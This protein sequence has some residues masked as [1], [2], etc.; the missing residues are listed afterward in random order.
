M[1]LFDILGEIIEVP[2]KL[3]QI[4]TKVLEEVDRATLDTGVGEALDDVSDA[5]IGAAGRALGGI[6]RDLD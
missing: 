4:P 3:A 6:V 5:T 1:G 2:F